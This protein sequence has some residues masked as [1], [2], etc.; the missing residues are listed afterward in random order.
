MEQGQC[1]IVRLETSPDD[2]ALTVTQMCILELTDTS[3]Q[4]CCIRHY[5]FVYIAERDIKMIEHERMLIVMFGT[6]VVVCQFN[7]T[8]PVLALVVLTTYPM[9][10][11]TLTTQSRAIKE[12]FET[13]IIHHF[14]RI[15]DHNQN[16]EFFSDTSYHLT[17][18]SEYKNIS[19]IQ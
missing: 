2:Y 15:E 3:K 12:C 19:A 8:S 9:S 6:D 13:L 5:S 1:H 7:N 4:L 10:R 11:L 17:P 16:V 18:S 14:S